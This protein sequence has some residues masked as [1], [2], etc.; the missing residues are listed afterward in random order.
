MSTK[1]ILSALVTLTLSTACQTDDSAPSNEPAAPAAAKNMSFFATSVGSGALGGAL[2][3]VEG[4]DA[5]C[6]ALADTALLPARVWHAY[7][8]SSA[9]HARIR[10]GAGPWYN[11]NG[12]LIAND[13]FE[14]HEYGLPNADS[15]YILDEYA[16]PVPAHEHDILT[17]SE[18]DGT[19]AG[20]NC[21]DWTSADPADFTRV[22][23]TDI[24]T[25][26]EE[27]GS[28]NAAHDSANCTEQGFMDRGGTGRLYCFAIDEN[29]AP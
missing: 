2:G 11:W 14:L 3:G 19:L 8:S 13:V 1:L 4:G 20:G 27:N 17:G 28:W 29:P 23:H 22:G 24:P 18:A 26:P 7:L 6:Q 9:E 21:Q 15:Q 12:A 5:F 10:I 25:D 16:Q